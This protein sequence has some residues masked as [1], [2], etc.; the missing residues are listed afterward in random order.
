[1]PS[2]I[3]CFS[4]I[5]RLVEGGNQILLATGFDGSLCPIADG[6]S[7][8]WYPKSSAKFWANSSTHVASS[9]P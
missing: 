7:N 9:S 5:D 1:M 4:E 8:A 2:A 3:A 6:P